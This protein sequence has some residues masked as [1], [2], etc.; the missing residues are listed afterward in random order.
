MDRAFLSDYIDSYTDF[1]KKGILFR[2]LSPLFGNPKLLNEVIDE[3]AN[4]DFCINAEA[5][6]AID[7]RGFLFGSMISMKL[8]KP[9]VL[10]RKPEIAWRIDFKSYNLEYGENSLSLQKKAIQNIILLYC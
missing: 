7:A 3:M 6:L 2:D 5:I 1:P 4:V 8:T 9:M 10:A